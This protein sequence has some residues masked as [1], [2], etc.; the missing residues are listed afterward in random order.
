MPTLIEHTI[1]ELAAAWRSLRRSPTYLIVV[2]V[3]IAIGIGANASVLGIIDIAYFRNLPVPHPETVVRVQCGDTAAIRRGSAASRCSF[4]EWRELSTRVRGLDGLAAY[5]MAELK[6]GGDLA[7]LEPYGAFVTGNYFGVL[8]V[9]PQRGRFIA[10]DEAMEGDPRP[11][12]VISDVLWH[13]V[14]GADDQVVGRHVIIGTSEFTIIGVTAPGF[15]GV[16]PEG[17]TDV[18]LPWT[19]RVFASGKDDYKN[20]DARAIWTPMIGRLSADASLAQVQGSL[21]NARREIAP[22]LTTAFTS[23]GYRATL[24]GRLLSRQEASNSFLTFF[25]AWSVVL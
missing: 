14:F 21:D 8:D 3:T 5:A 12:A 4:P 19:T 2:V 1:R 23:T 20:I 15:S 22:S 10:P 11:V 9:S 7:G 16:H 17:R 25:I 18:W 6:L 24:R 13:S